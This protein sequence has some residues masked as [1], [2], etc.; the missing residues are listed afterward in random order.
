MT[1]KF[2]VRNCFNNAV[3]FVASIDCTETTS[4]RTKLGLAVKWALC[5]GAKLSGAN[6][7]DANLSGCQPVRCQTCPVPTCPVPTCPLPTYP[8]PACPVPTYPVP[9]CPVP[10]YPMPTYPVLKTPSLQSRVLGL[11]PAG[12]L[13]GWKKCQGNI[14]VKLR[15]PESAKRSFCIRA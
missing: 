10:T 5:F 11:L 14:I 13:I 9:N 15:I 12:D 2:E 7:S 4:Y 1:I 6:L 8:V 3:Q